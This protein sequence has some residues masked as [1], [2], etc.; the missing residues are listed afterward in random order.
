M[1][2]REA[3]EVGVLKKVGK[4]GQ[5]KAAEDPAGGAGMMSVRV[6]G[7]RESLASSQCL[8]TSATQ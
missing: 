2:P 4:E 1:S 6:C 8:S 3:E 5:M 7:P